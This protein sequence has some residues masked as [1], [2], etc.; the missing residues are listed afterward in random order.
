VQAEIAVDPG[1][2]VFDEIPAGTSAEQ[3]VTVTSVGQDDLVIGNV[4]V[5]DPLGDPFSIVSDGCSGK[6]LPQGTGCQITVRFAPQAA[7]NSSDHFDIP[8]NDGGNPSVAVAVSGSAR[9]VNPIP[10]LG[11]FGR[12]IL[13]ILMA[14]IGADILRRRRL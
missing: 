11:G 1:S 8:S 2:L 9:E 4:A 12:M 5:A 10:T 14:C 7:G 3:A 13:A 6:T